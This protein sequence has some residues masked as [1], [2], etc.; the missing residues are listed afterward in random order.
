MLGKTEERSVHFAKDS[1]YL[2]EHYW[3]LAG[4]VSLFPEIG[5][6][7]PD[8]GPYSAFS[9]TL[10]LFLTQNSDEK[11]HTIL[12][13]GLVQTRSPGILL[14]ANEPNIQ[15]QVT[16][17]T[18]TVETCTSKAQIPQ[19]TWTHIACVCDGKNLKIY[20]NGTF[21][22]ELHL[23]GKLITN[24]CPFFINKLP[25]GL[26]QNESTIGGIEGSIQ[27]MRFYLR[28]LKEEEIKVL[29]ESSLKKPGEVLLKSPTTSHQEFE[30]FLKNVQWTLPM[31]DQLIELMNNIAD[32]QGKDLFDINLE[33]IKPPTELLNRYHLIRNISLSV[34]KFRFSAIRQFNVKLMTVLPL[35]DFSQSHLSWSLAHSLMQLKGITFMST[36]LQLWTKIL[37]NTNAHRGAAHVTIDR[38]RALKAKESMEV[39]CSMLII[40]GGDPD[41]S[42]SVFGQ[43]F[44][45]LH[46]LPP[47][48]LR[49]RGQVWKVEY[50]GEGGTDA[51]SFHLS[52]SW[53]LLC[54]RWF[55]QRLYFTCLLRF[56]VTLC[57][58]VYSCSKL[59]RFW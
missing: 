17:T 48:T 35:I 52:S 30:E 43:L 42:K 55:V 54:L 46:F 13:K 49:R 50:K 33:E 11:A 15:F 26:Q 20:I 39:I 59:E 23:Q 3:P 25:L 40:E 5:I 7:Y 56:A 34:L 9:V 4:D 18:E 53:F 24:C 29:A 8:P 19:K 44:R 6:A 37:A 2:L 16:T 38:P 28:P 22:S 58:L 36:K 41:G 27:N 32:Q 51:G 57:S 10:S 1:S 31:D 14:A 45:Q 21:D 47:T 12:V